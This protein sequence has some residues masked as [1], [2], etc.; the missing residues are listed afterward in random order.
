MPRRGR[1]AIAGVPW[2]VIQRGNNR[3][4][5]FFSVADYRFYLDT[6]RAQAEAWECAIHAYVLMSN[7]VHLLLTP[8]RADGP[9]L[10]MKHLGQRYV[11]YFNR[12]HQ[13]SG[14]LWEGRFRSCLAQEET[15]ALICSRYIELNPVRAGMVADPSDYPWSSYHANAQGALD[16]LLTPSESYRALAMDPGT[17][18]QRYRALFNMT[19]EPDT[20]TH[21]RRATNG[22]FALGDENFDVHMAAMLARRVVPGKSGRP[23]R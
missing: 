23:R 1:L 3:S 8:A 17:R 15:Y 20:V 7:H 14:S 11:Q 5:C 9:S 18:Q 22:C 12:R 16:P 13:R 21:I 2:H 4:R 19:L 6:L 10:L